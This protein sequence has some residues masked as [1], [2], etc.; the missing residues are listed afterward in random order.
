MLCGQHPAS[1]VSPSPHQI[2]WYWDYDTLKTPSQRWV[3]NYFK[4]V[5]PNL[6][7]GV[8]SRWTELRKRAGIESTLPV[9]GSVAVALAGIAGLG[10]YAYRSRT[11]VETARRTRSAA[12]PGCRGSESVDGVEETGRDRQVQRAQTQ[13]PTP[14]PA[15]APGP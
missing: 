5:L 2:A 8:R 9:F 15:L 10:L 6:V 13:A 7:A 14:G 12:E 11:I 4:T 1:A 3:Q